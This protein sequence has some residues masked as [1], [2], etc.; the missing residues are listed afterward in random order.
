[1]T[2]PASKARPI[3]AVSNRREGNFECSSAST[4]NDTIDTIRE[5][6]TR[7]AGTTQIHNSQHLGG[8][9]SKSQAAG[10]RWNQILSL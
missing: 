2:K 9:A 4:L 10:P 8:S 6:A 5:E 7:L 3:L 1:M